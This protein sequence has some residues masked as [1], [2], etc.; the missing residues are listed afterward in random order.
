MHPLVIT[1]AGELQPHDGAG[2][3]H[4]GAA[5]QHVGAG[6]QHV[7]AGAG[8]QQVGAGVQ[9]LEVLPHPPLRPARLPNR[10]A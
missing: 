5:L 2:A 7:G 8:A 10:P 1:G 3:Q 6:L 9:Q 4:V